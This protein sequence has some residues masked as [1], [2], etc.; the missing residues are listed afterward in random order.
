M[1]IEEIHATEI[2]HRMIQLK[3]WLLEAIIDSKQ[4][5]CNFLK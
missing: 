2:F 4:N 3:E 5:E 1:K